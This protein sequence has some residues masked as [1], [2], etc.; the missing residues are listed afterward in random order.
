LKYLYI[1]IPVGVV[2]IDVGWLDGEPMNY[3]KI[4]DIKDLSAT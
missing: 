2:G 3:M 4:S 1:G